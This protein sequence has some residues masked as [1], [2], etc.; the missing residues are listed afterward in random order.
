MSSAKP[1]FCFSTVKKQS[2]NS[3]WVNK[4]ASNEKES[5][6]ICLLELTGNVSCMEKLIM[7]LYLEVPWSPSPQVYRNIKIPL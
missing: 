6:D 5:N 3:L 2:T 7:P 4:S 1:V